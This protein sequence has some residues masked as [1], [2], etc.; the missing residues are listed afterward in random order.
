[1][2]LNDV[3]GLCSYPWYRT[4]QNTGLAFQL[5]NDFFFSG[6]PTYILSNIVNILLISSKGY[7]PLWVKHTVG[8]LLYTNMLSRYQTYK[9]KW[10]K[11]FTYITKIAWIE[12][13]FVFSCKKV[14]VDWLTLW[15][16]GWAS[17]ASLVCP[18]P[19]TTAGSL[20]LDLLPKNPQSLS[21]P[22]DT[23]CDE[24]DDQQWQCDHSRHTQHNDKRKF[25][26]SIVYSGGRDKRRKQTLGKKKTKKRKQTEM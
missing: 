7:S 13:L 19:S 4:Y 5:E 20:Y 10:T 3:P 2:P 23:C 18:L 9:P 12:Y 24:C 25:G 21:V 26:G 15:G 8:I 11:I 6:E 14:S 1:M 17:L 16:R 22:P